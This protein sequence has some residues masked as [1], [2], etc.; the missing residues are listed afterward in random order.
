MRTQTLDGV[1]GPER[2]LAT[3]WTGLIDHLA[4]VD[5][6]FV[7][8]GP[9][10]AKITETAVTLLDWN[11]NLRVDAWSAPSSSLVPGGGN[12]LLVGQAPPSPAP[13]CSARRA[14]STASMPVGMR[15]PCV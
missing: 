4:I 15:P 5:D 9:P 11:P 2:V 10:F 14:H 3:G 12:L 7:V 6:G 1:L 8:L 13:S